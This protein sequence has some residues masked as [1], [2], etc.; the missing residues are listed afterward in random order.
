MNIPVGAGPA[1]RQQARPAQPDHLGG[2]TVVIFSFFFTASYMLRWLSI[3]QDMTGDPGCTT[4]SRKV[5]F[6][7]IPL[8]G[9]LLTARRS[10]G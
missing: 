3:R 6:A 4:K 10:S 1:A 2:V 5:A 9:V 8:F 7:S